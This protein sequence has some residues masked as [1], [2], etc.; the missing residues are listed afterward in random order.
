ME[1]IQAVM[2]LEIL[3]KPADHVK[4]SLTELVGKLGEEQGIKVLNKEIHEPLPV[5]DSADLFT[6]FAEVEVEFETIEKYLAVLFAYMPSN[7]EIIHPE[8]FQ[9]TSA[10]LNELGNKVI[11]RMHNYDAI[12]KKILIER[13]LTINKLKQI[14]P[15]VFEQLFGKP[16]EQQKKELV[17][18]E[19]K[20]RSKSKKK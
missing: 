7:V 8:K 13:D 20:E 9:L 16:Q 5:K 6:T 14:A 17:V 3:G 15:N 1:K 19:K 2:I 18:G 12:T 4:N 11:Q 10:Y